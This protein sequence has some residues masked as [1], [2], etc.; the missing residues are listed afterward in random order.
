M[1]CADYTPTSEG[2]LFDW[3][4]AAAVEELRT[5]G[6]TVVPGVVLEEDLQK[7]RANMWQTLAEL[8]APLPVPVSKEDESTWVTVRRE[9]KPMKTMLFQWYGIGHAQGPWDVR[10]NPRVASVFGK[11]WDVANE[12][13]ISSFDGVAISLPPEKING[14]KA[15]NSS[16][17]FDKNVEQWL[18]KDQNIDRSDLCAIQGLVSV[19][20]VREDD[21]TF[22]C[23]PKS[24]T[25]GKAELA[26]IVSAQDLKNMGAR[27]FV[28][29]TEEQVAAIETL[30]G[31]K[32][33]RVLC[34]AGSMILWDSRLVHSGVPPKKGRAQPNTRYA[35]YVS[36]LPRAVTDEAHL[37]GKVEML[38]AGY[39]SSHWAHGTSYFPKEPMRT[40]GHKRPTL[41]RVTFAK[42]TPLGLQLAGYPKGWT[43]QPKWD[44]SKVQKVS[45]PKA[46]RALPNLKRLQRK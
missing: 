20:D 3:N 25:V 10:Q 1:Y 41:G 14:S 4:P 22:Y 30:T 21:A 11:L 6:F 32:G 24:H 43:A 7:I 31:T 45:R 17:G 36:M 44:Y 28:R 38:E 8:T 9:L 40:Y 35:I 23:I 33:Q 39:M 5:N 46:F 42:L 15:K 2:L 29:F 16:A 12:D 37:K 34:S 19:Y 26:S 27:D 18:H 13:L